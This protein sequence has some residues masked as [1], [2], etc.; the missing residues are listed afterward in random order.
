M[1]NIACHTICPFSQQRH[2]FC[3]DKFANVIEH[4]GVTGEQAKHKL[5]CESPSGGCS[6][7]A[8]STSHTQSKAQLAARE[9]ELMRTRGSGGGSE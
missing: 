9:A 5:N 7:Q 3:A 4:V 6:T 1:L 2:P 8:S